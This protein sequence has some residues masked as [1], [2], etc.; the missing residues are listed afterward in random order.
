LEQNCST[1][2]A[3]AN[4]SIYPTRQ[5]LR[6]T[7]NCSPRT[8]IRQDASWYGVAFFRIGSYAE[9]IKAHTQAL[10]I[11]PDDAQ[12]HYCLALIHIDLKDK[13]AA[14]K[15]HRILSELAQTA[16]AD[17]LLTEIHWQFSR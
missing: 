4:L 12:A 3:G 17:Q 14:L 9:A 7:V 5:R 10:Q 15:E 11:K 13:E 2:C 1:D 6:P 16:I 8:T